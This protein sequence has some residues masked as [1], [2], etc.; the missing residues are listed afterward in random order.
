MSQRRAVTGIAAY[1]SIDFWK[2][3]VGTSDNFVY[4]RYAHTFLSSNDSSPLVLV[5]ADLFAISAG[6]ERK[7]DQKI[8]YIIST[9]TLDGPC[10]RL[11]KT[12]QFPNVILYFYKQ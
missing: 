7:V 9:T 1:P 11:L 2:E 5:S 4:N 10:R 6:C 8:N 12:L 3:E